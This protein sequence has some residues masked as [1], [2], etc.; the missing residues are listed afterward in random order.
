MRNI[1]FIASRGNPTHFIAI[2]EACPK[3]NEKY[4]TS[5]FSPMGPSFSL[6]GF[7]FNFHCSIGPDIEYRLKEMYLKRY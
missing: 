5:A 6:K 2:E 7:F 3:I 4:G 1:I